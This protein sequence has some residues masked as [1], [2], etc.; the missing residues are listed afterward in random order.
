MFRCLYSLF[1]FIYLNCKIYRSHLT[2]CSASMFSLK[3][4][5][6][7][8]TVIL[9]C[10]KHGPFLNQALYNRC[11]LYAVKIILLHI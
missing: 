9:I 10:F 11:L 7:V 3:L 8:H 6:N 5:V 1:A 2:N 4:A